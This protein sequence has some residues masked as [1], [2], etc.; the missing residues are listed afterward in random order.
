MP[1]LDP[2]DGE[3]DVEDGKRLKSASLWLRYGVSLLTIGSVYAGFSFFTPVLQ[4]ESGFSANMTS[5][6]LLLYGIFTLIGNFLVGSIAQ[7]SATVILLAGHVVIFMAM[8]VIYLFSE[9]KIA[10]VVAVLAVGLL[11][12]SMNPALVARVVQ[13]G[14]AGNMVTSVHTGVI[15][16][17]V[18]VGTAL[19]SLIISRLNG[20]ASYSGLVSAVLVV[21]VSVLTL[22]SLSKKRE[23]V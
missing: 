12:V 23:N 9:V 6:L 16:M 21:M 17:G 18:T 14:G 8:M 19:S 13:V 15:T 7:K 22:I 3:E 4:D 1:F 10:T 20:V 2:V 11:G 5:A